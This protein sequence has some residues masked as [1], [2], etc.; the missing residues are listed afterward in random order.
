ML[1]V[2]KWTTVDVFYQDTKEGK[3]LA[4]KKRKYLE[5]LGYEFQQTT[6]DILYTEELYCDQYIKNGKTIYDEEGLS[7]WNKYKIKFKKRKN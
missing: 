4:S 7:R 1:E 3:K 6:N 5:E 2:R